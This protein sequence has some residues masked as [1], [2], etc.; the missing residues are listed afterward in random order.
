MN[1]ITSKRLKDLDKINKL[2]TC[3]NSRSR[4]AV[5]K[6]C[7]TSPVF[8]SIKAISKNVTTKNTPSMELKL[9][10]QNVFKDLRRDNIL[11]LSPT[12]EGAL[13]GV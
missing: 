7:D 10:V 13:E 6:A 1:A 5:E 12:K 3:K 11:M 8:R 9:I 2:V 4:T